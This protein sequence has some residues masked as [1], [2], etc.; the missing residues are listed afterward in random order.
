[1]RHTS[2]VLDIEPYLTHDASLIYSQHISEPLYFPAL[3]SGF[4]EVDIQSSI[5]V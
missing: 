5:T 1:M 3:K 2:R 4:Q